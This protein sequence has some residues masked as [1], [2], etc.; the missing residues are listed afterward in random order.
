MTLVTLR[1]AVILPTVQYPP[2]KAACTEALSPHLFAI[3]LHQPL[4]PTRHADSR[5]GVGEK[6][7]LILSPPVVE[8]V[9]IGGVSHGS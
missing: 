5:F 4:C 3:D 1:R 9:P 6:D 7:E 2:P 8:E